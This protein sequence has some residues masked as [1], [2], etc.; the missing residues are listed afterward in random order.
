MMTECAVFLPG[1]NEGMLYLPPGDVL[2]ETW[3]IAQFL[4]ITYILVLI[5]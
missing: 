5:D 1:F 2:P 4:L 3:N